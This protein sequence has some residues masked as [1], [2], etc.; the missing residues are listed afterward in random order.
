[1]REE[2]F[3]HGT[4]R[5]EPFSHGAHHPLDYISPD[6][7]GH[8][9][10]EP[11]TPYQPRRHRHEYHEPPE[12]RPRVWLVVLIL[13]LVGFGGFELYRRAASV[14]PPRAT[15]A[16]PSAER[17]P[18]EPPPAE[19]TAPAPMPGGTPGSIEP[20]TDAQQ[21]A[22]VGSSVGLAV[23]VGDE[24]GDDAARATVRF[25]LRQGTGALDPQVARTDAEGVARAALLLPPRPGEILVEAAV[26][27][28]T[29]PPVTFAVDAR[30]GPPVRVMPV[31]G[32][33]QEAEVE[34][35]LPEPIVVRVADELDNPVV[36]AEIHFEVVAGAGAVA[37]P[38]VLTDSLG[39]AAATWRLGGTPG[40]QL[41]Q[42][43]SPVVGFPAMF[44][45]TAR[46]ASARL[47]APLPSPSGAQDPPPARSA[48]GESPPGFGRDAVAARDPFGAAAG[49]GAAVTVVRRDFTVGGTH[50][51][52]LSGGIATCRGGDDRGQSSGSADGVMAVAAGMSHVCALDAEGRASC[53]GGNDSGQLGD[54]SREDRG[55]PSAVESD[56]R[57]SAIAA[58]ASHTCGL[59][60]W[61]QAAC[62]GQNLSG[63][64]GDGTRGDRFTPVTVSGAMFERLVAGWSHTCGVT[65]AGELY[66]WGSNAEGQLGDGTGLDRLV[67]RSISGSVEDVVAGSSH[68]CAI[69]DGAVSCWGDNTFG[70]LG[71]GSTQRR[72]EPTPVAELPGRPVSLAAGAV[73]TCALLADGTAHC[74]GQNRHGQLGDGTTMNA[75]IPAEVSGGLSFSE[76][77]AG[78]GVTCGLSREGGRYCWGLNQSGQL[79]DGSRTSRSAPAPVGR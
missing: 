56:L 76:L 54:G 72:P 19:P 48:T 30:T 11:W 78:G 34:G 32:D 9:G 18:T 69:M 51:C 21:R 16:V 22:L 55:S 70:Q 24:N 13:M 52:T 14:G 58:G 17:G 33:H 68:T 41:V 47:D 2:P 57:F 10:P 53:W 74:W 46:G 23:W 43:R 61:G 44:T 62:W 75:T 35:P 26:Q 3:S 5:E 36:G 25:S 38:R 29:L 59:T 8:H 6:A 7:L 12:R 39:R 40:T 42:A 4:R 15:Q 67:P 28:S 49:G 79:G 66:C 1:M 77:S 45:A 65:V 20:A 31:R 37:P 50:V 73:H 27:G 60:A 71:D 63:Q 64:L